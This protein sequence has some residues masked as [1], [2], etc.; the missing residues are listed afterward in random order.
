M[1]S[2]FLPTLLS[3]LFIKGILAPAQTK[4]LPTAGAAV[5]NIEGIRWGNGENEAMGI[6]RLTSGRKRMVIS[7]AWAE[8]AGLLKTGRVRVKLSPNPLAD[9][10]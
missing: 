5:N 9:T 1:N 6:L 3:F 2:W 7:Y 4:Q 8:T 10:T